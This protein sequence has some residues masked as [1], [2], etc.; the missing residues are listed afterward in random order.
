[1]HSTGYLFY[2]GASG[3]FGITSA[4]AEDSVTLS[5]D[6]YKVSTFLLKS[7]KENNLVLPLLVKKASQPEKRL[8]SLARDIK[9]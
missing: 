8:M 3:G 6:G 2:S 7:N 4:K 5:L 1:M 9:P